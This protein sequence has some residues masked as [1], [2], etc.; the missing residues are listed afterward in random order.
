MMN[1]ELGNDFITLVDEDGV[2]TEFEHV[3]TLEQGG[4]TY[5]ALVPVY[6]KASEVLND[7]GELV[8]LKV[9]LDEETGEEVLSTIEDDDEYD[10]VADAFADRLE[11]YYEIES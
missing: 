2:E 1:E 11:D 3:D 5:V 9:V 8:I 10:D 4:Q 7:Q 6:D